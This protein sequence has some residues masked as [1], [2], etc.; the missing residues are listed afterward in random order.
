MQY[1]AQRLGSVLPSASAGVSQIAKSLKAQGHD[2]IDL[3]LGEPDFAT[4][5]HII[6]AA[7]EAARSGQT[8]YPPTDGPAELKA[9]IA[10]KFQRDNA[11]DYQSNEIIVSNGAKQVIFN[12]LMATSEP[13]QKVLLCAPYFDS[14]ENIA[15]LQGL[16]PVII[17]CSPD[18][19]FRLTP[20][21][22]NAH[23]TAD[24]R[25]LMLNSPSN[26]GGVV[27]SRAE[28]E[29]IAQVLLQHPQVLILSDEIYEKILFDGN[30]ALSLA[31]VCP[32]LKDRVLTVNGVSKAYAMT[33]WRIGYGAGAQ[34]LIAAMTT[35]QSQISSGACSIAQAAAAAALNGPQDSVAEFCN[36]FR[37][38]R[39]LVVERIAA[40]DKLE[41]PAPGG[42]FYALIRC[43]ELLGT[44]TP[45]GV[46]IDSV[47]D[48][49]EHLLQQY[50]VAAVPGTAYAADGFFRISTATSNDLLATALDRLE[51]CVAQLT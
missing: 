41:L 9:A 14:Y 49:V 11:L 24:T 43:S 8:R 16:Q 15:L 28:L 2:V 40:I 30:E 34:P 38:R 7:H 17:P 19:G 51:Q 23:L 29:S 12:A 1:R 46:A 35:V 22:L 44:T 4:P 25:W 5:D 6:D 42:A 32:A 27:Y 50:K 36:V 3:G 13:G 18:N 37:G 31:A 39:D 10:A 26:P 21:L 47:A 33:G 45:D 20:E 48:F